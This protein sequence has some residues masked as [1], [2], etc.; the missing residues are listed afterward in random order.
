MKKQ[1]LD[2]LLIEMGLAATR[3]QAQGLI[4]AGRVT[5]DGALS[6]KA[7]RLTP[8][9]AHIVIQPA[10][11]YVSRGGVKL[12]AAL[13]AFGLD[14]QG[15]EC[16]DVGASTGGFTD[17]LLQRGA[18]HV[19][20]ID[21]GYGQLAW[22]LRQDARVTVIERANVRYM[23]ALPGGAPVDLATVDVSFIGL[24]L[25]IPPLLSWLRAPVAAGI[26]ALI[27]PQFEAG[28]G[29]VG[30]GGVVKEP[31]VHRAVLQQTLAWAQQQRLDVLGL[32][33]SPITGPAGNV[34]FLTWLR[35]GDGAGD[36]EQMVAAV[37]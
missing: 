5:V 32:I 20:A 35:P 9:T 16:A 1:R 11:A 17:C 29:Q 2:A 4:L 27:K 18:A 19:F 36:I 3:S 22:K 23:V 26:V 24:N 31:A 14:V 8:D 7:G 12:A 15:L 37:V 6:D 13:D 28:R 25:V 21:V 34:E 30:K 33:R 10:L